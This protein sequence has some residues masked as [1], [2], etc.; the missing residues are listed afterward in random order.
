MLLQLQVDSPLQNHFEELGIDFI[1]I[2]GKKRGGMKLLFLQVA[3]YEMVC[4]LAL[5]CIKI[6]K[7]H[8]EDV[9]FLLDIKAPEAQ[10]NI[11]VWK[12]VAW[13]GSI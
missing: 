9:S 1:F 2:S 4:E 3:G 6:G 12:P 13:K 7:Y 8:L 10:E 5:N 11:Q